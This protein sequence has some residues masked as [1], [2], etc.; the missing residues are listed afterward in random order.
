MRSNSISILNSLNEKEL[1]RLEEF[2]NSPFLVKPNST[3]LKFYKILKENLEE[4]KNGNFSNK[5]IFNVLFKNKK[6]NDAVI[7]NLHSDLIHILEKFIT[8]NFIENDEILKNY[9]LLYGLNERNLDAL[10]KKKFLET[11]ELIKESKEKSEDYSLNKYKVNLIKMN[12]ILKE[13][14]IIDRKGQILK[15]EYEKLNKNFEE[16]AIFIFLRNYFLNLSQRPY[17]FYGDEK[18]FFFDNIMEYVRESELSKYPFRAGIYYYTIML[19]KEKEFAKYYNKLKE[20]LKN[21]GK[22]LT[23]FEKKYIF[24]TM[25]NKLDHVCY[26]GNPE[27]FPELFNILNEM[28]KNKTCMDESGKYISPLFYLQYTA[29]HTN[30]HKLTTAKAFIETYKEKLKPEHRESLYGLCLG[31]YY[32]RSGDFSTAL[33]SLAVIEY[34][35]WVYYTKIKRLQAMCLFEMKKYDTIIYILRSLKT[36]VK[37][38]KLISEEKRKLN[39]E[40]CRYMQRLAT[41]TEKENIYELKKLKEEIS[42]K[43][44]LPVHREWF[45]SKLNTIKT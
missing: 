3:L 16:Y 26:S 7:R 29:Y 12:N 8:Y 44:L 41:Y 21:K 22:Y 14:F 43:N 37:T 6:F 2:L 4:I 11:A 23:H 10:F 36:F 40:F 42:A 15:E 39:L 20:L 1:K 5:D 19:S 30:K 17:E 27:F 34:D 31:N 24:N 28:I 45:M 32:F 13:I 33:K 25:L 9:K 35:N 38:N 18:L